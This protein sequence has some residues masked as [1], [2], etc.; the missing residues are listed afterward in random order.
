MLVP[1]HQS[2]RL[3]MLHRIYGED[4]QTEDV[5]KA[6]ELYGVTLPGTLLIIKY[7]KIYYQNLDPCILSLYLKGFYGFFLT[8]GCYCFWKQNVST[9]KQKMWFNWLLKA[10]SFQADSARRL[11]VWIDIHVSLVVWDARNLV[12]LRNAKIKRF[13]SQV[14]LDWIPPELHSWFVLWPRYMTPLGLSFLI[15]KMGI[16]KPASQDCFSQ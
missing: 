6:I 1:R 3:G 7:F 5:K 13:W 15:Y 4:E 16:I 9:A 2:V 10:C 11:Q 8:Q 12:L 14:E